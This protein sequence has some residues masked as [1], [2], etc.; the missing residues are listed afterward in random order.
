MATRGLRQTGGGAQ[1]ADRDQVG[2]G[3]GAVGLAGE[4]GDVD[5]GGERELRQVA[6]VRT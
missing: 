3:G 2:E 4:G 5:R 1:P 6:M